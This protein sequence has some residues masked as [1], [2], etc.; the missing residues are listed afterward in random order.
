MTSAQILSILMSMGFA[1]AFTAVLRKLFTKPDGTC[2]IDGKWV[3]ISAAVFGVAG[4]VLS[5]YATHIPEVVWDVM[6]PLIGVILAVG[7]VQAL[8]GKKVAPSVT[9][10]VIQVPKIPP[11]IT[12]LCL[13]AIL[14][15]VSACWAAKPAC[16]VVDAVHDTCVVFNYTGPN[17][18]KQTLVMNREEARDMAMHLAA[19]RA[20]L[21]PPNDAGADR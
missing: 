15:T 13:T 21:Q 7:G 12:M 17:G 1:V 3:Y 19:K 14:A 2:P 4:K 8:T 10:N 18:E 11:V 9:N 6:E 16:K 5:R 20:A